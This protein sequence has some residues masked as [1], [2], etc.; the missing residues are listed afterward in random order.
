MKTLCVLHQD[1]RRAGLRFYPGNLI[2]AATLTISKYY[3]FRI[4]PNSNNVLAPRD[5]GSSIE[6]IRLFVQHTSDQE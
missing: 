2:K 3:I 4:T 6:P 5:G 1:Q